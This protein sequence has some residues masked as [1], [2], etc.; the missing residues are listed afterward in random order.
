[1]NKVLFTRRMTKSSDCSTKIVVALV[2]GLLIGG[3]FMVLVQNKFF[4]QPKP[5]DDKA[6]AKQPKPCTYT[7]KI[8]RTVSTTKDCSFAES[9]LQEGKEHKIDGET[10]SDSLLVK[11]MNDVGWRVNRGSSENGWNAVLVLPSPLKY[12]CDAHATSSK[13]VVI[14][15]SFVGECP[16][17]EIVCPNGIMMNPPADAQFSDEGRDALQEATNNVQEQLTQCVK[18]MDKQ[19]PTTSGETAKRYR[20]TYSNNKEVT[21]KLAVK[22]TFCDRRGV[23]LLKAYT[24]DEQYDSIEFAKDENGAP[25]METIKQYLQALAN[26]AEITAIK[27]FILSD[28][29]DTTAEF[30]G[31]LASG[32]PE[33]F[34]EYPSRKGAGNR[35]YGVSKT[36]MDDYIAGVVRSVWH[37]HAINNDGDPEQEGPSIADFNGI[38]TKTNGEA[39]ITYMGKDASGKICFNVKFY[40]GPNIVVDLGDY[41]P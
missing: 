15:R 20:Y 19:C 27:N 23:T 17:I 26:P 5:D 41:D 35:G 31:G 33:Q 21:E 8:G 38:T 6:V 18:V 3:V 28:L 7:C 30:G 39:I 14:T 13:E 29:A 9:L 1:M 22:K 36:L 25:R 10:P 2:I 24:S 16:P 37:M 11:R 34:K 12:R 40:T 4:K 32:P